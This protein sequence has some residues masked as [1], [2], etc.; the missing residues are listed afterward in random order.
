MYY[1]DHYL[2]SCFELTW[3]CAL[4]YP[5]VFLDHATSETEQQRTSAGLKE[6]FLET[7]IGQSKDHKESP[8]FPDCNIF[9]SLGFFWEPVEWTVFS[10]R[11]WDRHWIIWN[12]G[13]LPWTY[14]ARKTCSISCSK[15][16]RENE[17]MCCAGS[18]DSQT[19]SWWQDQRQMLKTFAR[20]KTR[21]ILKQFI[22]H[23]F[24]FVWK[25]MV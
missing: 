10:S 14:L 21:K 19:Q 23:V 25:H 5:R 16:Q 13:R 22:I 18:Q 15:D 3:Q 12:T 8:L 1:F 17:K 2:L 7:S 4:P 20:K 9:L 6:F 11:Q 24:Y